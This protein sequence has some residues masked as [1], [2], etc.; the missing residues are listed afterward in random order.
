MR[1]TNEQAKRIITDIRASNPNIVAGFAV[2]PRDQYASS[3]ELYEEIEIYYKRALGE[4][5]SLKM[6]S[7]TQG[8]YG[9]DF[10]SY[11]FPFMIPNMEQ[12]DCIFCF[13]E[14]HGNQFRWKAMFRYIAGDEI[15]YSTTI[16]IA[17]S[18]SSDRTEH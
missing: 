17:Y 18:A 6:I 7:S 3:N 16:R 13:I 4:L 14:I 15:E 12:L 9:K 1:I 2:L 5:E 8:G 11:G 10:R